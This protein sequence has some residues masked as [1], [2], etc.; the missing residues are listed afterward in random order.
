VLCTRWFLQ[1]GYR[2]INTLEVAHLAESL[3]FSGSAEI[4]ADKVL[5]VVEQSIS[6]MNSGIW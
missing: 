2:L 3:V 4:A 5:I 1:S 6:V